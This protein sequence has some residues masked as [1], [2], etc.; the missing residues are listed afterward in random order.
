MVETSPSRMVIVVNIASLA[1]LLSTSA[2]LLWVCMDV[3][4]FNEVN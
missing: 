2:L 4:I 1:Y 3:L